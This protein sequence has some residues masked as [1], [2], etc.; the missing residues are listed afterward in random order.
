MIDETYIDPHYSKIK[1]ALEHA[2]R[3]IDEEKRDQIRRR[4]ALLKEKN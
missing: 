2:K 3:V 1:R 4:K